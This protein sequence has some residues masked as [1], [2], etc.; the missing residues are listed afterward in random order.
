MA[1]QLATAARSDDARAEA[2]REI[3]ALAVEAMKGLAFAT[4]SAGLEPRL[5]ARRAYDIAEAFAAERARRMK[6]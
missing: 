5:L 1:Q 2:Q 6:G 4:A 3:D